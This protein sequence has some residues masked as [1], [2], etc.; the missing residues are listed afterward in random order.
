[1]FQQRHIDLFWSK[2]NTSSNTGCWTWS[3]YKDRDGYGIFAIRNYGVYKAHRFVFLSQGITIPD[4]HVVMHIC[5]NPSCVRACHLKIGTVQ[6]NN[7]DKKLKKRAIAP[8]GEQHNSVKLTQDQI[9]DIRQRAQLGSRR[10]A[11]NGGSNLKKLAQEYNVTKPTI[12]NIISN[13]TWRHV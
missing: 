3:A 10:T 12:Y 7:T 4:R 8:R 11:H 5:D 9:L 2:V 13:K 1:M 6:D